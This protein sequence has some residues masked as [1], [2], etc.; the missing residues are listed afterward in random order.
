MSDIRRIRGRR[1]ATIAGLVA[2]AGLALAGTALAGSPAAE[3]AYKEA[4]VPGTPCTVTAKACVDLDSQKAWLFKDGKVLRGPVPV[5]TGGN[6]QAT[7]AGHSLR[8]YRKDAKHV[9]QE[10][11]LP[12][13][14]PA[15]MPLSVFFNDG[16]I[17][18]HSGSPNRS[19]AGCVHL[20]RADA[21]AWFDYLQVGDKVQ[22]LSAKAE[23]AA[24]AQK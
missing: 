23:T 21:Q 20:N 18:F 9:S 24:R 1:R 7:P 13:G 12:N 8:V 11:R 4:Q 5:A 16:G 22:V 10:S 2:T 3:A 6:G 19:S 17:A 15:P 14:A